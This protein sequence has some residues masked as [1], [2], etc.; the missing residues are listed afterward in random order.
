M[1]ILSVRDHLILP[2]KCARVFLGKECVVLPYQATD[3]DVYHLVTALLLFHLYEKYLLDRQKELPN[4]MDQC[5]DKIK[6]EYMPEQIQGNQKRSQLP[7][8]WPFVEYYCH[9][10]TL[11]CLAD[12]RQASLSLE[13]PLILLQLESYEQDLIFS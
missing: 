1:P 8:P 6:D 10:Q 3:E 13:L 5:H 9:N 7:F 2:N 11:G 12:E 4:E